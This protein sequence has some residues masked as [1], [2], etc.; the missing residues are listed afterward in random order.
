M[1]A[2]NDTAAWDDAAQLSS[3]RGRNAAQRVFAHDVAMH[4]AWRHAVDVNAVVPPGPFGQVLVPGE[5]YRPLHAPE[6]LVGRPFALLAD[7]MSPLIAIWEAGCV[8][9][10]LTQQRI[11][12]SLP[13]CAG[14]EALQGE[15]SR[16][17]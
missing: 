11:C 15:N 4:A 3:Q 16:E 5:G 2:V 13:T 9:T 1:N 8:L 10:L 17:E 12:L 14:G 6:A 7:P